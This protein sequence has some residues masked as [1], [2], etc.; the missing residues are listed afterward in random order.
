[1]IARIFCLKVNVF[2]LDESD[3]EAQTE[4]QLKMCSSEATL[5]WVRDVSAHQSVLLSGDKLDLLPPSPSF[6][7]DGYYI[8]HSPSTFTLGKA[9]PPKSYNS[10]K[11]VLKYTFLHVDFLV[12]CD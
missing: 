9:G 4:A 10:I 1:M 11:S 8:I 6:V 12:V 2:R 5:W 3:P 7:R